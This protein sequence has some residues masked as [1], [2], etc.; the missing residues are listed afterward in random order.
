MS[1]VLTEATAG[2]GS[3]LGVVVNDFSLQVA[4]A[5]GSGSQTANSVLMRSIFQMGVPVSGKNLFPSNIQGLPTWFTIRASKHGYIGRK[6]EIDVLVCMNPETAEE[7]VRE[8]RPG[9]HV[10]YEKKLGLENPGKKRDDVTYYPVP[11]AELVVKI[12]AAPE[13]A[14]LRKLIVNMIYV[15]V[16]ADL[17]GIDPAESE[18]AIA[19]QLKGKK[20]AVD[21]NVS[22]VKLG[23]DYA[24]ANF[25]AKIPYRVER[26]NATAGKIIVEGNAAAA[27]GCVFA[28][29]TVCAWYPITPS[30]SLCESFIDFCDELRVDPATGKKNVAVIQ[31]EDEIASIGM[32]VG[33]GWAGAR[34]FTSTS[35][36]GVSLMSEIIGLGY[37]TE[38]PA[39]IFDVQRV[40]PSTGLPTRTMQGDVLLCYFNSHGD[41][42]HPVL[43]P[44]SPEE[45]FTMAGDA[46]DLAERLQTPVF[47]LTDLDLGMNNWM[48]D[49]FPY[50]TAPL[51]RGKVLDAAAIE[52]VKDTWG[53]YKD[54]DGDAIPYRTLPGTDSAAGAF[55]TRGSGHNEKAQ[56]SEKAADYVNNVDRLS[57]KFDTARTLV[58]KP[59]IQDRP[60]AVAGVLAYGT[61]HYGTAEGRDKLAAEF[62]VPLDYCRLRALPVGPETAAWIRR[63]ERIYV[64]EQNRDS[65]LV[66]ILRDE[67]PE[68]AAKFVPI[69]QYNGLPLDATTVVEG[70]LSDRKTSGKK[71]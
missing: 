69:R 31:A 10:V 61:S 58:P 68:L 4:T 53:R 67:F 52:K 22:A 15:G 19:K 11:F 14:K 50:P 51:D 55:F 38:V 64:V 71:G 5:N 66:T 37:Y 62:G 41:A 39:V 65:Q 27:L 28:G 7:D 35:G 17:M 3:S 20:K 30:S 32:V 60:G 54:V 12:T 29:A 40:G 46:F 26:M 25:P 47:V 2:A 6:R 44:A 59:E 42:K 49:A 36:P 9:A 21:L 8:A 56:Y 23:L 43:F 63:H 34:A 70:V 45:C 16:V 18:I 13:H 48:S 1:S 33:A 24:A 57:R